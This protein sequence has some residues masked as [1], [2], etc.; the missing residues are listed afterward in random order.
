MRVPVRVL[1]LAPFL[2]L[3]QCKPSVGSSCDKGESRC[4][5]GQRA[6]VCQAGKYIE[7]L[8]RGKGGCR[9]EA[10]G[11][12]CDIH[13]NEDGDL[14][15][16]DDEGAA[17]CVDTKTLVACRKGAYTRVACRGPGGCVEEGGNARCDTSVAEAGEPCAED[18]KKACSTDGKRV[19]S[20]SNGKM[21]A[22]YEC[23]G[24][25][26]CVSQGS[27]LDCDFSVAMLGDACDEKLEGHFA[28]DADKK[29]IVRCSGGK[30]VADEACK[31]GTTCQSGGGSTK[32]EKPM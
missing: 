24:A 2:L 25:K 14:C 32:C 12:A 16:T 4:I 7:T 22:R 11:T 15:S 26:G 27:K 18:G 9:L 28:C 31:K 29:Q 20:C 3:T 13:A 8:C 1:A 21:A 17:A 30:F 19:L 10:A 5:D 6:L 23:R